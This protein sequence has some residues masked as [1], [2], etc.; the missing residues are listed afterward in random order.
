MKFWGA[1]G[2]CAKISQQEK[3]SRSDT[4]IIVETP[5]SSWCSD[6][7]GFTWRS[8]CHRYREGLGADKG[9]AMGG[10]DGGAGADGYFTVDV[11]CD[12]CGHVWLDGYRDKPWFNAH[13]AGR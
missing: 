4:H 7:G 3:P 1:V 5:E 2:F 10:L 13:G 12:R 9:T 11:K 8:C 6:S